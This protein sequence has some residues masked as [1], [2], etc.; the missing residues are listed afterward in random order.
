M[1]GKLNTAHISEIIFT[2]G[3]ANQ[4]HNRVHGWPIRGIRG[5]VGDVVG[6]SSTHHSHIVHHNPGVV[7]LTDQHSNKEVGHRIDIA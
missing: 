4:V 7:S 3:W 5:T 6:G 1:C 2:T